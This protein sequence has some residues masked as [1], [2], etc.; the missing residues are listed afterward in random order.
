MKNTS[1]LPKPRFFACAVVLLSAI[2][3]HTQQQPQVLHNH[4][5]PAVA[6]RQGA[7]RELLSPIYAGS[8]VVGQTPQSVLNGTAT[9]VGHYNPSQMLRLV[10]G[11]QPPHMAEEEQFL[12][13]L[14]TKGSPQFH[15]FLTAE[16]WNT[17]FAPSARDEQAVVDWAVSV[18]L[19]VTHRYPNRLL[20]DVEAPAGAIEKA[21][22]IVINS[23]Q[24][25]NT[26]FFSNDRDP[27]IPPSLL[28]TVHSI[29]GFNNL[30]GMHGA[31]KGSNHSNR[32]PAYVSGPVESLGSTIR[33]DGD[34]TKLPA[35][36]ARRS[37]EGGVPLITNGAYDPT[38]IYSSNAY[39][40]EALSNLGHCCNP[41]NAPS[42]SPPEAS[43]AIAAF[44]DVSFNDLA[45]FQ[46]LYPYLAYNVTKINIDGTYSCGVS[47]DN[48]AETTMDTEY[49]MAMANS[50]GSWVNT[51]QI[52][53]YEG[54]NENNSTFTDMYNF[55]LTQ[56]YA[57]VF[58]TSWGCTE[59]ATY[60]GSD[61]E[62]GTM[63]TRHAI[64]DQMI[65][66]G[67]T[68]V[69]ASDDKGATS[70]CMTDSV[71]YPASDPDFVA[72][73]GTLL[74]LNSEGT[75]ES[76]VGWTGDT[77]SG[78]CLQNHG[79]SGGGI[80]AFWPV[81]P[82][83]APTKGFRMLPDI[84]LNAAGYQNIYFNGVLQPSGGTSIVA[85]E[86]A[87]FFAEENAY[88]LSLGNVCGGQSCAPLGNANYA[89]WDE[90]RNA[91]APH[92]PFY[93]IT[94]GCDSNDITAEYGLLYY[95]A[96]PGYDVVTGWG[97][98]NMLQLAWAIN[99]Y[100]A[101]DGGYP[102]ITF[103]GPPT[104]KWY[105]TDQTVNW[106]V[107]EISAAGYL[108]NGVA[109]FS[110]AWDS[111]PG[112]PY[113]ESTPGSGNSFY[114]GPQFAS[115]TSGSFNL[116]AAGSQAC[117][118]LNVLA[119][120]N[121]G[122]SSFDQTYGPLCYDTIA[123]QTVASLSGTATVQV[124]LTG[125]D[126]ASGV[127][128]TVYQLDAGVVQ[129]YT[130][131]F[132]VSSSGSHTVT[133]HSTDKAGNVE[134]TESVTFTVG[135]QTYTLTAIDSGQG[136]I[137][138]KDGQ[139]NCN[140]N[141]G[142]CSANY[143]IGAVATLSE[144][145]AAGWTF[146]SWGGACTGSGSCS[147]TMN[148][149]Q[150]VSATFT[151]NSSTYTLT[152]TD[153]GQGTVTSNVGGINCVNGTGTCSA[154]YSGGTS[155]VLSA[156]PAANWS[157]SGW[158]G[159]SCSGT[160]TCT[161]AMN[162]NQN[163]T[164]TFSQNASR[165]NLTVVD[166][167]QGTIT[168]TDTL[169]DCV[170]NV[171]ICTESYP[172]GSIVTL[173]ASAPAGWAFSGWSG[174]CTGT[175]SCLVAMTAA[176]TVT[177]SFTYTGTGYT[178]SGQATYNGSGMSG[179]TMSLSEGATE[180]TTTDSS[181]NYSFTG[182]T[183]GI[184]YLVT[185]SLP[186]YTFN[187][188]GWG[189]DPLNYNETA[190]FVAS[191]ATYTLTVTESGQ[192]SVTSLDGAISC[193]N[194]A[195][196]CTANYTSG[197]NVT[198]N[199]KPG[200]GWQFYGW[201][202]ACYGTGS[203]TLTINSSQ[204]VTASFSQ[205]TGQLVALPAF[206]PGIISDVAGNGTGA[207]S[208]D[209]GSPTAAEMNVPL[210]VAVDGHGTIYVADFNN[211]RVRAINTTS[212]T[213][214]IAGVVVQPGTIQTVVG[215]GQAGFSGDGG[216][217][218]NAQ[219]FGPT[220][221]TLDA[222]GDLFIADADNNR[223]RVVNVQSNSITVLG[224]NVAP[225][226]IQ[227]VA[228][229]GIEGYSGDNVPAIS[230]EIANPQGL[231][232]DAA[233][234]LYISDS[235]NNRIRMVAAASGLIN[236]VAGSGHGGPDGDGQ[237]AIDAS[238]SD[239]VAVSVDPQGNIYIA[240]A[241][242]LRVRVVYEAGTIAGL[243]NL[244]V[245]Y[246]YTIAGAGSGCS[247]QTDAVGDGCPSV[248]AGP[249]IA[250]GLVLDPG[251]SLYIADF[252]NALLRR[253]D[254]TTGIISAVA[255]NGAPGY[256]G[257]GGP[258]TL[259]QLG[260]NSYWYGSVLAVD[261]SG[262]LYFGDGSN[263]RVR[264][265][266]A[267]AAPLTF[268]ATNLGQTSAP[269]PVA[270]Q[271][272][273]N[274]AMY[275]TGFAI[276]GG[277]AGDF[278]QSNTC[279]VSPAPLAAGASCSITLT[280]TPSQ[281]G[282]RSSTLTI[283]DNAATGTQTISLTG[284]TPTA[285]TTITSGASSI[286]S[287]SATLSGSV[288][289]NGLDTEVWFRYGTDP[290]L[291]SNVLSTPEQDQGAGTGT[292]TFNISVGSL[293]SGTT[294]Y[295]QANASNS[296]GSTA[297]SILN[298]Q[299]A[300][301][302]FSITG[303]VTYN[304]S[305][306]SGVTISLSGGE[307][308]TTTTDSSGNYSFT[309]LGGGGSY[310]VTP[311]LSGYGFTPTNVSFGALNSNQ[312]ANFTAALSVAAALTPSSLLFA[313][314]AVGTLS[315][316]QTAILTNIGTTT[317]TVTSIIVTGMNSGDFLQTNNC[318]TSLAP[319][320]TCTIS[321]TFS[322]QAAGARSATLSV[323]D[324]ATG[325]PQ[326]VALT[327]TGTAP[328]VTF[329]PTSLSF[330]NQAVGTSSTAQLVTLTN[331]GTATLTITSIAVTGTN[332]TDFS[333]TNNCGTSLAAGVGCT[334]SV[335]FSPQAS[336]A[337]SATLSVTDNA[338][339]SPQ[340][341]ALT[342]TGTAP[343]VTFSP[344]SLSFGNQAVGTSSTA[345]LVTLTNSGTATLT[346]TSI[347][348]TGTNSTDFS[349]TNNCGTS[350]AAGASCTLNI[351]FKPTAT[352]ARTASLS[353]T[354]NAAGSPQTVSL[355]GT[356]TAPAVT[357]SPT[358]LSF[359]NQAVGTSSTAQLVTL[360]NSGTATLTIASVAVTGTNSADFSQT[361]NCGTSLAAGANCTLNVTFKPTTTGT[362]SASLSVTDNATGSPQT[363]ALT[364]TGTAPA[365]TFSPTSLSF[366]NQSVGTSSAAQLVTLSNSG[367]ATLTITSIAV[368]GTN[369]ADFSQ[370]NNCGASLAVGLSC[371]V[372]V[373]F[374]PQASGTRNATL[375]VTDNATGSPQTV[376][377]TGTGTAPAVA[378]S[379]TSLSFGNQS[380]GTSSTA[381][382]V[383]M[384]NSGTAILTITLIK[385][386]GTNSG[387][388][389]QT[390]NCG[391]S[392]AAGASC[393]LNLTFK[394]T[395]TGTRSASLSV[396]D[397][398]TG[399]PQKVSLTGTGTAPAVIFSPTSLSFGNQSV[400]TSSTAKPVTMTNSGT[401]ILTITLI[402]ITGTNSGDFSQTNNCGTSLAAG[403][404]CTL[405][406]TFKPTA[407]GTR[408]ASLS[409]T[410]NATGSPQTVALT[411][412]GTAPA[413]TF[414]PTSLSFGDQ[415]VGTSSASKPVKLTNSG[416]A[417]LT[418]TLI[419][420]TGTNSGDF[421]QTNNCGTNVAAGASCTLNVTFKP[422]AKGSRSASLSVTDNATGSPQTVSLMGTGD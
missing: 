370:T 337:R 302:T 201:S 273:G 249:I 146:S 244:Q 297:G 119:W 412:T 377:L 368:S 258:A 160:G 62:A 380:V 328:A 5:P 405:N 399:S 233:G 382:P 139:I 347:A 355:T 17:R 46:N 398:A 33:H 162:G 129:T 191:Q 312:N 171:G 336:G 209:G 407:T 354:D 420:I 110:Q 341:V 69:A 389:S 333:Q 294:Y 330:G 266:S 157:F 133:F 88:L 375:S 169:I 75:Y 19:T 289:P 7:S 59:F 24:I 332:S 310:T 111:D 118:T 422:A 121:I 78:A 343:A 204:A 239:P 80:S 292:V 324:N 198:L 195:G 172:S 414:S 31:M 155:V 156:S 307:T 39:D 313:N 283:T 404:S 320:T 270:L 125:T 272:D 285:P 395:A 345:Q 189:F 43:I 26:S 406:L 109:G 348:V 268:P 315:A 208:G 400:G 85:P 141:V 199:A 32:G 250:E 54:A 35:H 100:L 339:G 123:P 3:G 376:A 76:E 89:I 37:H 136:T 58:T 318:G 177:A 364:G 316:V 215:T 232:L 396:T 38:D 230:T 154:T 18:G 84:A 27:F 314:Q 357:F 295:F 82:Y 126:N 10:F 205:S 257:D 167:G 415:K 403:A 30:Q 175:G 98:A 234:D 264:L 164:A 150:W 188:G 81:P 287:N 65:G 170:N 213:I 223:V 277:N 374:S 6:N 371:T 385:I 255:G 276:S 362:R 222:A 148:S 413:V 183:G 102:I 299:T 144:S 383:T 49:A 390:N 210:G 366:G 350:L 217:P 356:G 387:D 45:A 101:D 93:D 114:S 291:S 193:T 408:S 116:A 50:F 79:G 262:N 237:P 367:T 72:A 36:Q 149:T 44:G 174:F 200:A 286:T 184:N 187:P 301:S 20:V 4:V 214:T 298:F 14:Y 176:R 245:G 331:S 15:R 163:V 278:A 152:V 263:N 64:F 21:F 105:N 137:T 40:Y 417:T 107:A 216:P 279:P 296:A 311:S 421:S 227:T 56:G 153:S 240:E 202:G 247:Q 90:G 221:L 284:T 211:N 28:S 384:T 145:P 86:L 179:V 326:T 305:G 228:G 186:G 52:F 87:G 251:G 185:P 219:I 275:I 304:G 9:I 271:N 151:Q 365:V 117:H 67:W 241:G 203:C 168:S 231:A 103:S 131:P 300:T 74:S 60:S 344:T 220:G 147:V 280:F 92:N 379:P 342:G 143:N 242:I 22:G 197:T 196:S 42:G 51:A 363:V 402:K 246:I 180:T 12:K 25:A 226:T 369:S 267:A 212:G 66:Q 418:I 352:G 77:Y 308:A 61:C 361:N 113:S 349:Q 346:I 309:G 392:L 329:S 269:Q 360:T 229:N 207:F 260:F 334:V 397:N 122:R 181:G 124:T 23:Y 192:G 419:K 325:S 135:G 94:S 1:I 130:G 182:L 48:C 381:K 281:S 138:S 238:L 120:N 83:Q 235:A 256:S 91:Y 2:L 95:C 259:A 401:A 290:T 173:N 115:A 253:I 11:L 68:L 71:N 108:P 372:S 317:L 335:T 96:A 142:T 104:N 8:P 293:T 194:G 274:A 41:N 393:T 29:D 165:Y 319:G 322:P 97:S 73:G 166:A 410:D 409:V 106:N 236:T 158:S 388:F 190:N 340:T 206:T 13:D 323:A 248:N 394:P 261:S 140:Y 224:V 338:T 57:S 358:S 128:S 386:T 391:T 378:F 225:G 416:T 373:T 70:D 359:G 63:D 132:I 306:L 351:T 47:D 178:I 53:V 353:V 243:S 265:V 254:H 127:A 112:D 161:V 303:Q 99:W 327:G 134:T 411:G 34:S 288:N 55:M 159:S 218:I 321:V 252:K 16:Q 282:T